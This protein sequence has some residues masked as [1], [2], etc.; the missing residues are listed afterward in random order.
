MMTDKIEVYIA[1]HKAYDVRKADCTVPIVVGAAGSKIHIDNGLARDDRGDCISG[2]NPY[3]CELTALYW[4]WR[5]S[6]ADIVGLCHYRRMF[7]EERGWAGLE[8]ISEASIRKLVGDGNGVILPRPRCYW[9]FS[10]RT[11]FCFSHV[12]ADLI[13]IRGIVGRLTPD[14]LRAYDYVMEGHRLYLYNMF[15]CGCDTIRRYCEWVFPVLEEAWHLE[16]HKGRDQ[17]QARVYGFLGERLFNVWLRQNRDR[18]R[19]VEMPV[20]ELEKVGAVAKILGVS[21]R[22]VKYY[23]GGT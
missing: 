1:M 18:L 3:Y 10:V 15:I 7:A 17:R 13:T 6:Q 2:R 22:I 16:L 12:G 5:N 8:T 23:Y 14:Y 21:R 4:I 9:P 20:M 19:V 11:H